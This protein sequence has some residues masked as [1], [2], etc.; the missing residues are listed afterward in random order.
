MM[1]IGEWLVE[2]GRHHYEAIKR[3]GI[4]QTQRR[5]PALPRVL[6]DEEERGTSG[7][8]CRVLGILSRFI[9]DEEHPT[10]A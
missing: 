10:N 4:E 5:R 8:V 9:H 7:V 1:R 2:S 3:S 6:Q